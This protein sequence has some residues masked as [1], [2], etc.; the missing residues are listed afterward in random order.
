MAGRRSH[1][2]VTRAAPAGDR[3]AGAGERLLEV[4]DSAVRGL[5]PDQQLLELAETRG[6][7]SEA[8]GPDP[9]RYQLAL[10]RRRVCAA[11]RIAGKR[12]GAAARWARVA[13]GAHRAG[14]LAVEPAHAHPTEGRGRRSGA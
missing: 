5:V 11:V 12:R 6:A 10:A 7:L 4:V 8:Y 2:G 13:A 1:D 9:A 14:S 3:G